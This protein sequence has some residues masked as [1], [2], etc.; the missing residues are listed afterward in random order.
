MYIKSDVRGVWLAME[1]KLVTSQYFYNFTTNINLI[2]LHLPVT[3][4]GGKQRH[5]G[6]WTLPHIQ[7][8]KKEGTILKCRR[9]AQYMWATWRL[10]SKGRF[11]G[12]KSVGGQFWHHLLSM[13]EH[14]GPMHGRRQAPHQQQKLGAPAWRGEGGSGVKSKWSNPASPHV[15][16][17]MNTK[18]REERKQTHDLSF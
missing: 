15:L 9:P 4:K 3:S 12:C 16:C 18:R 14:W 8:G 17:Y 6:L 2:F 10:H 11:V 1:G 5:T 7:W 13:A